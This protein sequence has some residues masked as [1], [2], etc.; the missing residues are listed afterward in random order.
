MR[1]G[2]GA[3]LVE[4]AD[5]RMLELHSDPRFVEKHLDEVAVCLEMR[6]DPLDHK[7]AMVTVCVGVASE[8]NFRHSAERE[9]P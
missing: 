5:I 1:P 6:K 2:V 9:P 3:E 4:L 7:E 8:K